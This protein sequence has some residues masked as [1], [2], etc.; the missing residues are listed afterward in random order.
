MWGHSYGVCQT[1]SCSKNVIIPL[2]WGHSYGVCQTN[3]CSKNVIIP[4]MWGHSYG[5]C[6]TNSCSEN[7]IIPLMWGH[8]YGVCQ[9][10]SCSKNVIIPLMWGYSLRSLPNKLLQWECHYPSDVRI[11]TAESAKPTPA[12]RML[13]SLWCEDIHCGVCQTNSCSQL[14]LVRMAWAMSSHIYVNWLFTP[15]QTGWSY[16]SDKS[17]T[18]ARTPRLHQNA[19]CYMLS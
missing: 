19:V 11:F 15:S 8:S 6:Q 2:M 3:S 12:V 5:V 18:P 13:L 4:L 17:F 10:N 7:V 16:P 1:N 14:G 9:T